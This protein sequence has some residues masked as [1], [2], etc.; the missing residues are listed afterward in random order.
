MTVRQ[1]AWL[2]CRKQGRRDRGNATGRCKKIHDQLNIRREH[3]A[4]G[5]DRCAAPRGST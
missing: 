3:S 1:T 2:S 4:S 5:R